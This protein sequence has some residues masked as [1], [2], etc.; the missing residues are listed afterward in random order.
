MTGCCHLAEDWIRKRKASSREAPLDLD[1]GKARTT[2]PVFPAGTTSRHGSLVR[3]GPADRRLPMAWITLIAAGLLE[4]GWAVGLK[5]TVG[6]T[7]LW[8]S[9]LTVAA[10]VLSMYLL[11]LAARTLPIGTAYAVW[12]GIGAVGTAL[13]GMAMFDEPHTAARLVCLVAIVAGVAGL[14]LFEAQ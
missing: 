1:A 11:A 13:F 2:F 6:F 7:R 5:Y 9:V 8:P 3:D 12:V 10:M 4:V 14:R